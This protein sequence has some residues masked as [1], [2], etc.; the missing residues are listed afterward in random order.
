MEPEDIPE[1]NKLIIPICIGVAVLAT[2][3][4]VAYALHRRKKKIIADLEYDMVV[5]NEIVEYLEY[6]VAMTEEIIETVTD[7]PVVTDPVK[8]VEDNPELNRAAKPKV[9]YTAISRVT[10]PISE[11]VWLKLQTIDDEIE[12]EISVVHNIFEGRDDTWDHEMELQMRTAKDPY[13]IKD[14]EWLADDMGFKQVT[15]TYYALDDTMVDPYDTIIHDHAKIMGELKFG[16]GSNDNSLVY[17]RNEP[18]EMEYEVI[19]YNGSF[20]IEVLGQQ[21]EAAGDREL[22]HSHSVPRMRRE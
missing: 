13:V 6:D 19:L 17:I 4:G 14:E 11:E 10:S 22:Q 18:L 21:L 9:D 15:V 3:L 7:E 16:H 20:A 5:V 1:T 2:G 8:L 12:E